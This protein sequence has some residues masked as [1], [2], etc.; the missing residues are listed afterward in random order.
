MGDHTCERT[1][2]VS[3]ENSVY[4]REALFQEKSEANVSPLESIG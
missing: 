2:S 3:S 4:H 1:L